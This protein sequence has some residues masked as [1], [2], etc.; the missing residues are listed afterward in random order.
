MEQMNKYSTLL[1]IVALLFLLALSAFPTPAVAGAAQAPASAEQTND[2]GYEEFD[3]LDYF[4][5]YGDEYAQGPQVADPLYPINYTIF[6]INDFLFHNVGK[7]AATLLDWAVPRQ[8]R[9]WVK[10]FFTNLLFPVRFVNNLLQGKWD[11]AYMETS[12]FIMNTTWGALGLFDITATMERNW[13]PERPTA[14]G[15][16]QTMGKAGIGHGIYLYWPIIGPSS[17]RDSVGWFADAQLDPLTYTNLTFI[18]FAAIRSFK[19]LNKL[20]LD[21]EGNEYEALTKGAVDPYAA[22]RDGYLRFRA[23]KVKE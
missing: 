20:S 15:F 5:E 10:N 11:A 18:E 12:K 19:N 7:P 21:L 3:E 16:G 17:L 2:D 8:P 13:E 22:V 9:K 4:E 1:P 6:H 14:D 23:K